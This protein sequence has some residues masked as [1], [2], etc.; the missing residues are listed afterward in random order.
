MSAFKRLNNSD[1]VTLP[2]IA[3]KY[4]EFTACGSQNSG[5]RFYTGKKMSG[6]FSPSTEFAYGGEY[7][8]LVYD[9]INHLYYQEYSGSLLDDSSNLLGNN[10]QTATEYRPS[11]SYYNY[12]PEGYMVK[13]FPVE[14]GNEIK[15]I[16]VS[17]LV[18]GTSLN[19]GTF[20]ISASSYHFIDDGRGNI[21]DSFGSN[22]GSLVGNIF[23]K[24]GIVV[25]THQD[26]Q[27]AFP[28]PPSAVDDHYSFKKSVSPKVTYPLLN[29]DARNWTIITGSIELSG[30]YAS[31]FSA[32]LNG[33]VTF[34]GSNPGTYPVYYRYKSKSPDNNCEL[35]SNYA[36]LTVNVKSPD[37]YFEIVAELV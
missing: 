1:V 6:S 4:W 18:Y 23:Y 21:Y 25:V 34:S 9:N 22:S 35:Y 2:Y 29:D 8:R 16:G 30:S 28:I 24:H 11:G 27:N 20:E 14:Y 12:T 13:D 31:M 15:V 3:N 32:S 10:Y 33:S 37:C 19:P 7:E 5:L 26:Y 36:T 17:P